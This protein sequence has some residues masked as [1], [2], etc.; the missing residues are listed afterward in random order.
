MYQMLKNFDEYGTI[1]LLNGIVIFG[2]AA[3]WWVTSGT[4]TLIESPKRS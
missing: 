2:A 3:T 4:V 1:A